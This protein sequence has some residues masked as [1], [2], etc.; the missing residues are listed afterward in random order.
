[1]R[2]RLLSTTLRA[3]ISFRPAKPNHFSGTFTA[4]Y[5]LAQEATT[6]VIFNYDLYRFI[7]SLDCNKSHVNTP[8]RTFIYSY[9]SSRV[10]TNV[11]HGNVIR[12]V[13][14]CFLNSKKLS[15]GL[16]C[17][18]TRVRTICRV[19][20]ECIV[21]SFNRNRNRGRYKAAPVPQ[22]RRKMRDKEK[23]KKKH[24]E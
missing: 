21:N 22:L 11:L 19:S 9:I 12:F 24:K 4:S 18:S 6:A 1:M 10:F 15:L 23:A 13:Q 16:Q 5:I 20:R 7:S 14:L 3:G 17:R 2:L 8:R